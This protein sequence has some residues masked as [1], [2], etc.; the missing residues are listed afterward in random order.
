MS[1][2]PA[3]AAATTTAA[4]TT[5]FI[6]AD[7]STGPD[8]EGWYLQ[9]TPQP[10]F[11]GGT[12]TYYTSST[13]AQCYDPSSSAPMP[14]G[15]SD[16]LL[17]MASDMAGACDPAYTCGS[18][19]IY[20]TEGAPDDEGVTLYNCLANW[21]ADSIY[22]SLPARYVSETAGTEKTATAT[23]QSM[24]TAKLPHSKTA[25][26]SMPTATGTSS[27]SSGISGGAIAGIVVGC[28]AAVALVGL[29][30]FFR[31]KI[32]AFFGKGGPHADGGPTWS[33]VEAPPG[34]HSEMATAEGTV[35]PSEMSSEANAVH[36][37]GSSQTG[38]E[39]RPAVVHELS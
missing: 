28:V 12:L 30:F 20:P 17:L 8:F 16:T 23:K 14:T 25:S 19:K 31:K 6:P 35:P 39:G 27:S 5:T 18:Y 21:A 3:S 33:P 36:E 13:Y 24:T 4:P 26:I 2:A 10:I 37:I 22:R 7:Y 29:L 11:C 32:M 38:S 34:T 9:T 1:S 15:C